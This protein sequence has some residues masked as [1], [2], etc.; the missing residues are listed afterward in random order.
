MHQFLSV[1]YLTLLL[2]HVSATM[3]HPQE[4]CLYLLSYMPIWVLV[5]KILCGMWL[6][7]RQTDRYVPGRHVAYTQPQ[8][9]RIL[10]T[11][12]PNWHVTQKVQTSSLRMAHTCRNM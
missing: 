10:S 4:T 11:K 5:D 6:Y 3:C 7:H 2:L 12:N 8:L 1:Y 9:H